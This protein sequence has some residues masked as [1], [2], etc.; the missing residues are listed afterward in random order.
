MGHL[1]TG[2]Q[3]AER[4]NAAR[5]DSAIAVQADVSRRQDVDAMIASAVDHFGAVD[6][7]V[8]NAGIYP[9]ALF[10]D[11]EAELF[12]RVLAVN[13]IGAFNAMQAAARQMILQ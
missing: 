1:D 13:L 9:F 2:A 3:L 11:M 6:I 5:P 4:L 7:L 12:E 8:N 10:L